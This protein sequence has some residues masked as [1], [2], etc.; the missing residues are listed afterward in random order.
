M[1]RE[2]SRLL[3]DPLSC[4]TVRWKTCSAHAN[5][6]PRGCNDRLC[7]VII[8]RICI[9]VGK[10]ILRPCE[11]TS[12][13]RKGVAP[14]PILEQPEARSPNL[15]VQLIRKVES[16]G[17]AVDSLTSPAFTVAGFR[18]NINVEEVSSPPMTPTS[19]I[20]ITVSA[21]TL[22]KSHQYGPQMTY[23]VSKVNQ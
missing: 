3:S 7:D 16:L 1:L 12:A 8:D 2:A 18:R 15:I 6:H 20:P 10:A 5:L 9:L 17:P 19:T 21:D 13:R 4:P 11:D 23:H 14:S 22:F